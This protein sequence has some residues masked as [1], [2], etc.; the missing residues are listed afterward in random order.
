MR[1]ENKTDIERELKCISFFCSEYGLMYRKLGENDIDF[2]IH[3][4]GKL[5]SYVEVKGRNKKVSEAYPLPIACRKLVKLQDKRINPVIIW[6]CLDGIIFGY[7]S[8][9]E[10]KTRSGG[11]NPRENSIN[12][13]E[14]M[15][16]FDR[17]FAL[18]EKL[19]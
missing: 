7:T 3:K 12:D 19:F 1:F 6:A 18:K 4:N 2:S 9:I 16:Y 11:R 14:F 17:Q 15:A 10:G 13:M 5:I 8:E